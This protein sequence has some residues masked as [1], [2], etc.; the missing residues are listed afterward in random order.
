MLRASGRIFALLLVST[1]LPRVPATPPPTV[2]P[3][4]A[5]CP[6]SG[7]PDCPGARAHLVDWQS[8][9]V[10]GRRRCS[11]PSSSPPLLLR[12][13]LLHLPSLHPPPSLLLSSSRP[14]YL[15][16]SLLPGGAATAAQVS[17]GMLNGLCGGTGQAHY[18]DESL[19]VDSACAG[20]QDF[21]ENC[22]VLAPAIMVT[23][24]DC[25]AFQQA[26]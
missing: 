5:P 6:G 18:V 24:A 13:P 7:C 22:V 23:A 8:Y 4:A 10:A 2:S 15:P 16:A 14:M 12:P 20:A 19:T 25:C 11:S 9:L 21:Q 1:P 26:W 17:A 3:T